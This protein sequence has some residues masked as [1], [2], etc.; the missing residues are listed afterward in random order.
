M[1]KWENIPDPLHV[2]LKDHHKRLLEAV[3]ILT[4]VILIVLLIVLGGLEGW[5]AGFANS[6][7]IIVVP[8][9][10]LGWF[11]IEK[12]KIEIKGPKKH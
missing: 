4:L 6:V 2:D 1:F 5:P 8:I 7:V 12:S 9:I 3:W 11:L 10:I